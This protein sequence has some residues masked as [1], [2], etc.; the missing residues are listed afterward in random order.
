MLVPDDHVVE[1]GALR[2]VTGDRP[3]EGR[4]DQLVRPLHL[5]VPVAAVAIEGNVVL[6]MAAVDLEAL[7]PLGALG[8][9]PGPVVLPDRGRQPMLVL[10][11]DIVELDEHA[12]DQAHV[13]L[14]AQ[15][16][17]FL[18]AAGGQ[19][20]GEAGGLAH[21]VVERE[22]RRVEAADHL[23]PAE[24]VRRRHVRLVHL[25][26]ELVMLSERDEVAVPR[27]G[28]EA[29]DRALAGLAVDLGQHHVGLGLGERALALDRR[30]LAGIAEHQDRL[31]EAEKVGRH[32]GPDHRDLVEHEQ[33]AS[34]D[35]R[36]RVERE[37]RALHFAALL[38]HRDDRRVGD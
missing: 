5:P 24:Q 3:S 22:A 28:R 7:R 9:D 25:P 15:A 17:D 12:I 29:D 6:E 20:R 2:L 38:F 33:L 36:V 16:D 35:G 23:R 13:V 27:H 19:V 11:L 31:A 4:L 14:V 34:R 10:D 8:A 21:R 30:Q 32:L 26:H 18:P 1:A 37:A